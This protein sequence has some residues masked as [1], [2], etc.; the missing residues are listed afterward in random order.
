MI[1]TKQKLA[2]AA[3]ELIGFTSPIEFEQ[4]IL[5]DANQVQEILSL[6]HLQTAF[7]KHLHTALHR[8]GWSP[9]RPG[10]PASRWARCAAPPP[11]R[12]PSS[13]Q[14]TGTVSARAS[15][16]APAPAPRRPRHIRRA[17]AGRTRAADRLMRGAE[18]TFR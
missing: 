6:V 3:F 13:S 8:P 14:R 16:A 9:A 7:S 10:T 2:M 5:N 15:E 11:P 1:V 4:A 17:A 12:T 18:I